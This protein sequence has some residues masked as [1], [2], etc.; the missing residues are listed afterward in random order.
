MA[1]SSMIALSPTVAE[2]SDGAVAVAP[3]SIAAERPRANSFDVFDTLIARRCLEPW[4]IFERVGAKL[5]AANFVFHRKQAEAKVAIKPYTLDDIYAELVA[6]GRLTPEQAEAGKAAEIAAEIDNVVPIA[7]N[8][9]K[10]RDGDVL[11]S[12]MY[13]GETAIRQLLDKAGFTRKVGLVVSSDGKRSGDIWPKA[14]SRIAIGRHLG[15]N[16]VSDIE[17]PARHGIRCD[18]AAS[19][20]PSD[21]ETTL[22]G[23]NLRDLALLCREARLRTWTDDAPLRHLQLIQVNLNF[24]LLVLASVKLLRFVQETGAKRVLFSSRDS[25]LWLP[26][27]EAMARDAGVDCVSEY[28]YT[29][30]MAR[31]NPSPDYLAY[32]GARLG[33][34]SIVVDLCGTGWSLAHLADRLGLHGQ[35][36]FFIQKLPASADYEGKAATP[37]TCRFDCLIGAEQTDLS[38]TRLEMCNYADHASVRDVRLIHNAAVP[39]LEEDRRTGPVLNAIAEQRGAFATALSLLS[40]H[41][42]SQPLGL[43]DQALEELGLALYKALSEQTLLSTVFF[44]GHMA[45]ENDVMVS[46]GI[47]APHAI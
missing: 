14:L 17:M 16:R 41:R 30:R 2:Q 21:I 42:L 23:L 31:T 12:D 28:F 13:L 45:E 29:S 11:I 36:V 1:N 43:P 34:G 37:E 7:E 5:G 6:T 19:S 25:N 35:P 15:D 8:L 26:L 20:A 3:S 47:R 39:V 10:V 9:G 44:D 27:F 33:E 4:R 40:V 46:L 32:A 22:M 18:H 24:P 38:N